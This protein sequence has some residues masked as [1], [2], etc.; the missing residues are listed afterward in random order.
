MATMVNRDWWWVCYGVKKVHCVSQ[1]LVNHTCQ[2]VSDGKEFT[3]NSY[4]LYD[5]EETA[6]SVLGYR[7]ARPD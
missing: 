7:I 5:N 6:E 3:A 1:D 4:D 2:V